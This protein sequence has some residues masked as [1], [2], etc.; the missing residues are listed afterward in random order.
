M[1]KIVLHFSWF[2]LISQ[3]YF[4]TKLYLESPINDV[5][6]CDA[7]LT[8]V[9][10]FEGINNSLDMVTLVL[11]FTCFFTQITFLTKLC[12]KTRDVDFRGE[13][14]RNSKF[15]RVKKK[16][17]FRL[18]IAN[19]NGNNLPVQYVRR[20]Y[21][22][23]RDIFKGKVTNGRPKLLRRLSA[24]F[25][26]ERKRLRILLLKVYRKRLD[27]HLFNFHKMKRKTK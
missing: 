22:I 5:R 20:Q 27:D 14:E 13:I 8:G 4:L 19:T 23:S 17:K 15:L 9:E 12:L 1:R 16:A 6:Q 25:L 26:Y 3:I 24:I 2:P 21:L 18:I 7:T 11:L 10:L